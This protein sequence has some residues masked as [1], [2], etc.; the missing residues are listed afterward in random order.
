[1][2]R[3]RL[4]R[5]RLARPQEAIDAFEQ[6]LAED[7]EFWPALDELVLTAELAGDHVRLAAALERKLANP[8]DAGDPVAL[9]RRLSDLYEGPVADARNAIHAL[10]RWGDLDGAGPEPLRRL[11]VQYE[12]ADQSLELV[13]TL[14]GL[15][16][17]ERDPA[18]R[19]EATVAAALLAYEKL[20]DA[21]GGMARLAPLVSLS[22]LDADRALL[23]IAQRAE[24]LPEVY[25]LYAQ[26]GRY[27]DL[28]AQLQHAA[29]LESD[30]ARK[31]K[32]LR[33]AA[34]TLHE[35]L[36]DAERASE[37][38][39]AL[40]AIEEDPE[41]LRFMQA[42]ALEADDPHALAEVLLRLAKLE[43]DPH[44]L[45]DLLYEF[46][47]LQHFRLHAARVA[48]P[49]LQRILSELDP[50]F[51]PALDELISAAEAGDDAA[52]LAF[53]LARS[54]ERESDLGR[55]A[56][57]A[58]RLAGLYQD[59]LHD[60]ASAKRALISWIELEPSNLLPR[61]KLR[62][63]LTK[64]A[65][66]TELLGCL[67]GIVQRSASREE[68]SE[69]ALAA[70]R[71]CLGPLRDLD[72]AFARLSELMLNGVPQAEDAL[73]TLAF[74]SG[75]LD[76]LCDLYERGE[77]YDELCALLRERAEREA[78]PELRASL[79][80]RSARIL[81]HT[82]GDEFAAAEAYREA[83][84]LREE[85]EALEYL[86]GVA[87][88]QDDVDTLDDLLSRLAILNGGDARSQL[89][90]TRALLLRDRLNR[91]AEAVAL[92]VPLATLHESAIEPGLRALVIAELRTSAERVD[93]RVALAVALE[94][95]LDILRDPDARCVAALRL[96]DLYET[97]LPKPDPDRAAQAL[98]LACAAD[99][100]HL[101]A[102]RRLKPHLE[103]Q[104]AWLEY[105]MVL[106][107]LSQ[108]E[109]TPAERRS[110]RLLAAG[111]AH[112]QL[113]DA[114]SSL[115]RLS[116]LV[117][118]GDA[119]A[120]QLAQQICRVADLGRELSNLYILRARQATTP[121]DAQ[122]A[123]R[124]V[125]YIH[126]QWL[127]EP[128]E[129][130]EASL[131]LLAADPQNRSYLDDVDRLATSLQ[132]L[133]RLSQIYAK[134]VRAAPSD[135][136]RV[137]LCLRMSTLLE[138]RGGEPSA[139]LDFAMQAARFS[140]RD[141]E[142][143]A[144]VERLAHKQASHSELLWAEEQ[145]A[146]TAQSPEQAIDA[147]LAAAHTSDVGMRDR[148]QANACLRRALAL[149]E[150]APA[151]ADDIERTASELDAA[152]PELGEQDARRALLRA[153]LELAELSNAAFRIELTLRAARFARHALQDESGS[154]DAL[155]AGAGLPPFADPIL[156]ALEEA[157]LRSG[158][159][160]ALDGLLARNA[161]RCENDDDKRRLLARRA[162]VLSDRLERFDQAAQVYERLVELSPNDARAA[163]LLLACLRKAGRHR[164]LLR[165]CERRLLHLH[166]P[167]HKL[168]IMR[169]MA[170][171]WEVDLKNRA[172]A[173]AIWNDVREL[174]P[175]DEAASRAL[176]RLTAE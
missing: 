17:R 101:E 69:V 23:S 45:R 21:D 31:V 138:V 78:D 81:A 169:E 165:A 167:E 133:Q 42:R 147:W 109:S 91:P 80:L 121:A 132:A 90:L 51:E 174:A 87:E 37:A 148:E 8:A 56:E 162:R 75:K 126:E 135:A 119:E 15:A 144:R 150:R 29:R 172:S 111:A 176:L 125:M 76:A 163:E 52:A 164:E 84:S 73:H 175:H 168:A 34:R 48:I 141:P 145:R 63:L 33:R 155:R 140:P 96:A 71:L 131:R 149:S 44:E 98:R 129:A 118:A 158:R 12:R 47:H 18:A 85:R 128:E 89:L 97:Q 112:E 50:E 26:A 27:A 67:D 83:L 152:R 32:L 2:E 110:A 151:R 166:D 115:A 122:H 92:L 153:H 61:R 55:K 79:Y 86:S 6:A 102:R 66:H 39:Q 124:E 25:E 104:A 59:R 107:A 4:L 57:L 123:W 74:E 5:V 13:I 157:A 1:M 105:V 171:I 106:D 120:E 137:E 41:A 35:H 173:L 65:E 95:Q 40:L 136:Q 127:G 143:V 58:E 159:L 113:G 54:F 114:P 77:R 134:L 30:P 161:E 10:A 170:T 16:E 116:A 7:A 72:Q 160:D 60:D 146:A 22:D 94:G 70:A 82:V 62:V 11:R 49:V 28:V 43:T 19:V 14:D 130:F 9:L 3:G 99:P 64:N 117:L 156:D 46:A 68:R 93:D 53:G 154:F 20:K 139:A 103:R 24:R 108:L 100:R 88:R 36:N 142:L 38:Y